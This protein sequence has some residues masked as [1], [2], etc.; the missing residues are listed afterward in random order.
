MADKRNLSTDMYVLKLA[1][2]G[3]AVCY[4]VLPIA[5]L[6]FR[7]GHGQIFKSGNRKYTFDFQF[8]GN[9]NVCPICHRLRDIDGGIVHDL[10]LYYGQRLNVNMP[11]KRPYATL[12]VVAIATFT[13]SVT[14]LQEIHNRSVHDLDL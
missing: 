2:L 1:L 9:S 10:D 14:H 11:M 13:L 3:P 5:E 4:A 12:Y 7:K 8:V 6:T